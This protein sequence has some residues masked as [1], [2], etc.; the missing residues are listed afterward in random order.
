MR[1]RATIRTIINSKMYR[2]ARTVSKKE[3]KC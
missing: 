3:E 1:R 2:W